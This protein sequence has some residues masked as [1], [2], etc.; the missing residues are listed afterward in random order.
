MRPNNRSSSDCECCIYSCF[1]C[2]YL[3]F[4]IEYIIK[5]PCMCCCM[6]KIN[7][8]SPSQEIQETRE[9]PRSSIIERVQSSINNTRTIIPQFQQQNNLDTVDI[10]FDNINEELKEELKEEVY[11]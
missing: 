9:T 10:N 11:K 3:T 4:I 2:L 7:A 1:P 8:I 6:Y 5:C